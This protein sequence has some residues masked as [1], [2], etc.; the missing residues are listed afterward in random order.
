MLTLSFRLYLKAWIASSLGLLASLLLHC[1]TSS[2][3]ELRTTTETSLRPGS[4]VL[5]PSLEE[6]AEYILHDERDL[7]LPRYA[8]YALERLERPARSYALENYFYSLDIFRSL[9]E[10]LAS[11]SITAQA[12]NDHVLRDAP[13]SNRIYSETSLLSALEYFSHQPLSRID[14]ESGLTRLEA[15]QRTN[16]ASPEVESEIEFWLAEGYNTIGNAARARSHYDAAVKIVSDPRLNALSYFRRGELNEREA[17]LE[18]AQ[19]DFTKASAQGSS[20][21]RILA[22]LR[23]AAV[24]RLLSRFNDVLKETDRADSLLSH[25]TLR[26]RTSARYFDY[27]SPL[28]E[29]LYL[30]NTENDRIIGSAPD[31]AIAFNAAPSTI[32]LVSPFA[33]GEVA[34]LRGSALLD[35]GQLDKATTILKNG[36]QYVLSVEDSSKS[37]FISRQRQ[38]LLNALRFEHAWALFSSKNYEKASSEF[39][40]LAKADTMPRLLIRREATA[41]LREQG[42][43]ADPFYQEAATVTAPAIDPVLLRTTTIDTSFFFYND[44]PE[45]SRFYAGVALERAGK[46][47]E[48]QQIFVALGQDKSVLYS[49]RANY[50]LGLIRF[51]QQ[52]FI[53]AEA[54]LKPFS[55]EKSPQGV[56]ASLL[57]GEMAYR[58]NLYDKAI[59]YFTIAINGLDSTLPTL[60][61]AAYLERGLSYVPINSWK[62]AAS[63]LSDFLDTHP[64]KEYGRTDEALF[65]LGKALFR[66]GDLDGAKSDFETLMNEY[67]KSDRIVDAFYNHAWTLF[68]NSDY[69]TAAKEFQQVIALDSI[70]RF[71][72]DAL[73]RAGDSYYALNNLTKAADIYNQAVDRPAFNNLRTTRALYQLGVTRMRL[74][75]IR[76]SANVFS[77]LINKFPT[78]DIVDRA[79]FNLALAYYGINQ[80][81]QAEQAVEKI[82]TA[83]PQSATAPQALLLAGNE[84]LRKDDSKGAISYFQR[85]LDAY[86]TSKEAAPALFAQQDINIKLKRYAEAFAAADTFI[87]RFPQSYL[88]SSILLN[89]GKLQLSV[90]QP[91]PA[92]ETFQ[93]FLR[94]YPY[95]A[96]KSTARLL[97]GRATLA[98]GDTT[99]AL[100]IFGSVIDTFAGSDAAANA[101]LERARVEKKQKNAGAATADFNALLAMDYFSTDAAPQAMTEYAQFLADQNQKDSAIAVLQLLASRYPAETRIVARGLLTAGGYYS[102]LGKDDQALQAYNRVVTAHD[103]DLYGGSARTRRGEIYLK[104]DRNEDAITEFTTARKNS[105]LTEETEVRRLMGLSKAYIATGKK[106]D[107]ATTLRALLKHDLSDTDQRSAEQM[108]ASVAPKKAAKKPAA[109]KG[110]KK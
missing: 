11:S 43:F 97:L 109:K 31:H 15:I 92:R 51:Q 93:T 28:I 7:D 90:N 27:H 1:S 13:K 50:E 26:V 57:L 95:D 56:F 54:L 41:T 99:N 60:Q 91:G 70:T 81:A 68:R 73:S 25:S 5:A 16:A 82:R 9:S 80:N 23:R 14:I 71:A 101:Y 36:E 10:Y 108:L 98:S 103:K 37:V 4:P 63:D 2:A 6:D 74:D 53:Q 24:L 61:A 106:S 18:E 76:S 84:R 65:W 69:L 59:N 66:L 64:P 46:L 34:L 96:E 102:D 88:N 79:Y 78:S 8:G 40:A 47:T 67:P 42:F 77:Y 39:L 89:K 87:A 100:T 48:A 52:G 75:S 107:A 12:V 94:N 20:S 62:Q 85:I 32:Q 19:S 104:Q 29:E 33:Y 30:T 49:D 83:F 110:A 38:F 35:L 22:S 55:Y 105:S 17:R 58:K 44:F 21:L 86:P 45:R 72:Y 3:Q